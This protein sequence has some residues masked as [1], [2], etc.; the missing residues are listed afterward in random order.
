MQADLVATLYKGGKKVG[1]V[2]ATT[3][4]TKKLPLIPNRSRRSRMRQIPTRGPKSRCSI[5]PMTR[6]RGLALHVPEERGFRIHVDSEAEGAGFA[7]RATRRRSL[8]E[9][10]SW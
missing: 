6:E 8:G 3:P 1:M 5:W 9:L 7:C 10:G 4:G 2:L